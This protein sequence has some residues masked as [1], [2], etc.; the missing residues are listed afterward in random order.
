LP[1]DEGGTVLA[2]PRVVL[3]ALATALVACA[4]LTFVLVRSAR[5]SER[6]RVVEARERELEHELSAARAAAAQA[7][8]DQQLLARL[9]RDL[10]HVV[11]EMHSAAGARHIPRLLLAAVT[12]MLDPKKA[13]VAVRRRAVENDPD[14]HSRLAVAATVPPEWLPL[15]TEIQLGK[16]EIGF[17][18]EVQRVMERRDFEAQPPPERLRLREETPAGLQPDIVAPMIFKEE[19]VG[20]IAVEG[21]RR[22]IRDP[23]RLLAQVGAVSV[24]AHTRYVE[25]KATASLDGLTGIFNKRHLTQRVSEDL[26]RVM[27]ES[28]CLSVFIFDVD[29]FK[30]YND[31]NGH[32]AGDRLLR[33]LA[34]VVQGCIRRDAV[35]GRYGGEEFLILFPGARRSQALTAAENVRYAVAN[36]P[37]E[38]GA[39][40]PRGIVTISGGVAEGPEDGR[41]GTSLVAAADSALY[42]AKA[43]GRNRVLA[44]E[45]AYLG[46]SEP[47]EPIESPSDVTPEPGALL[48]LA[49]ITPA[50][51]V[52]ALTDQPSA[53]VLVAA[54]E[55]ASGAA[56]QGE[57]EAASRATTAE[58]GEPVLIVEDDEMARRAG[59]SGGR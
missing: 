22:G 54:I 43:A 51:G 40:Q 15:G 20:V 35:F 17:A 58:G 23:L 5:L 8:L 10:P 32:V 46:G 47:L 24:D 9:V 19:V 7:E 25:M 44:Y 52:S 4:A 38:F 11:H 39:L 37:F 49:H 31:R 16:G 29:H 27:D 36:H 13:L 55:R 59:R 12:R 6:I 1:V 53:D 34:K 18:A 45:P 41:D 26:R 57:G 30:K 2:S 42:R 56:A 33:E 21:V 14:R 50:F 48:S 3:L 28:S